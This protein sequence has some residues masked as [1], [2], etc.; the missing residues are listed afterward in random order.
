VN[1]YYPFT[2][3]DQFDDIAVKNAWKALVV[4]NKVSA[5]AFLANMRKTSR[6]N[7]R[8]PMQ[9]DDSPNAGF[10]TA[11]KPWL[12]VNPNYVEI[13]ARQELADP[14]SIY[15]YFRRMVDLRRSSQAFVYGDYRDLDPLNPNVFAYTRSIGLDKYVVVLNF[16][17]NPITYKFPDGITAK[18]LMISNLDKTGERGNTLHLHAWEA[19]VYRF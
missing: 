13:N 19:R 6:D 10:T 4:S 2:N 3:I 5:D 14:N 17:K 18:E 15:H 12:A 1:S 9:W 7:A 11:A 16:S 8:T